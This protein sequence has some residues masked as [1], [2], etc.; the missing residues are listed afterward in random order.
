MRNDRPRSRPRV[1]DFA[2]AIGVAILYVGC[3]KLGLALAFGAPQVTAVW[4][5]TGFAIAVVWLFGWRSVPGIYVGA[6]IA[7]A[8]AS[9]PLLV[10]GGIA[11]GN[12]LEAL[13]GVGLLRRLGFDGHLSTLHDVIAFMV[14]VTVSPIVSATVGVVSLGAGGVQPAARLAELWSLWWFGDTL[15]GL[16][17]T[18]FLLVWSGGR[19]LPRRRG[20][21]VEGGLLFAGLIAASALAFLRPPAEFFTI[22]YLI[23]PF[24]IWA[25]IR[26]GPTGTATAAVLVDAIAIWGTAL[27]RGPFGGEGP[28]QGL[29]LLQIF[30]AAAAVTGLLLGGVAA[31][32]RD[33]QE[34]AELSERRLLLAMSAARLGAWDWNVATGEVIWSSGLEP[35]HGIA[36]GGF[37]GTFDAFR[38]LIHPD[39]FDRVDTAIR[40]AVETRTPYEAEFRI[41]GEDGVTRWMAARGQIIGEAADELRMVGVGIDV[42]RQKELEAELREKARQLQEAD[43]RKDEFLAMLGH[44]LRNPLASIVYAAELLEKHDPLAAGQ[45]R[46]IIRR[47]SEHLTRL[48]DDL[49]DVARITRGTVR[50]ERQRVRVERV[51]A[52]AVES[53]S[54]LIVQRRQLFSIDGPAAPLW[55]DVDPMRF[56]QVISNLLHNAIKFSPEEAR[57]SIRVTEENGWAVIRVSDTGE[58]MTPEVRARVFELFAQGSPPLDRPQGGLGIGLTLV[59]RLVE[60]HGGSVEAASKGAGLGSEL[61][62]RIPAAPPPADASTVTA[63]AVSSPPARK[64]PRA[65]QILVVEDHADVRNVLQML[66]ERDGHH[67]RTASDGPGA[68]AEAQQR[69]PEVILLDIGLPG[70]NGYD[71]AREL[72]AIPRCANAYLIAVS[73]YGQRQDR[74]R[75]AAAGF[76]LHLLKPIEPMKLLELVRELP[77][78]SLDSGESNERG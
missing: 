42:T 8:S 66:L 14:A 62:V 2:I 74:A 43:R 65:R 59:R 26:F 67:V 34:R 50:L 54:D 5:P 60:L 77:D 52:P 49:L 48:V 58:G 21:V 18:P 11:L 69:P 17:V 37:E 24:I 3:A 1:L 38:A 35:L 10:A 13:V 70:S 9:E 57:I 16:V 75:S 63:K 19:Q 64:A 36:R 30:V 56:T 4:P 32:G 51:I 27:G 47:Q 7:N 61:T 55:I 25:A 46:A 29:V 33:A 78:R 31:Q 76:D 44:E 40:N 23:F 53:W 39:D 71:V 28:E 15:G 22:E 20:A 41:R 73:G 68:L 72:R 6:L 12:T 45:G